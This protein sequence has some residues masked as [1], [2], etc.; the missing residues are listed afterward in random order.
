[1][2]HPRRKTLAVK[3]G[4]DRDVLKYHQGVEQRL[5]R[6]PCPFLNI[7]QRRVAMCPKLAIE[8]LK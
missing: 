4:I 7:G 5:S 6:R 3:V 8:R 1:M 2:S